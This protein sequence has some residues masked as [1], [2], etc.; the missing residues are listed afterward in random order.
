VL[1][2]LLTAALLAALAEAFRRGEQLAEDVD[3]L[4]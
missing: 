1:T 3:G 2:V 4:V